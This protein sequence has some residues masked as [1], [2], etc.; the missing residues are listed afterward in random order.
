MEPTEV[1]DA[2]KIGSPADPSR[3]LYMLDMFYGFIIN[4]C[5]AR[6]SC[7]LTTLHTPPRS[8]IVKS[9]VDADNFQAKGWQRTQSLCCESTTALLLASTTITLLRVL[10]PTCRLTSQGPAA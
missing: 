6:K 4:H 7:N 10:L 3:V 1:T 9:M 8:S 2:T 5:L